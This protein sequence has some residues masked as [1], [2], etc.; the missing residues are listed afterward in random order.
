MNQYFC[1][2][3]ESSKI[4]LSELGKASSF[5]K[6]NYSSNQDKPRGRKFEHKNHREKFFFKTVRPRAL[7]F[8]I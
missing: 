3:K 2:H 5:P 6:S 4:L 8:G 7:I 1:V